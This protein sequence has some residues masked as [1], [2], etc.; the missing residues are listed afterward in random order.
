MAVL[1]VDKLRDRSRLQAEYWED[2]RWYRASFF[3]SLR[4]IITAELLDLTPKGIF[5]AFES[6]RSESS[7]H[8]SD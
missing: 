8:I 5:D 4:Y 3:C 1:V 2:V 7:S 6:T